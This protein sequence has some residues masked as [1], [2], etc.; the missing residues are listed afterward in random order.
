MVS[1]NTAD[2]VWQV[3]DGEAVVVELR[4][5]AYYSLNETGTYV[6]SRLVRG[7]NPDAIAATLAERLPVAPSAAAS[8]A[9]DF[10]RALLEAGLLVEG[11]SAG[12]SVFE[13]DLTIP[14]EYETPELTR[15]GKLEQLILSGE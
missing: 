2:A 1:L 5:S 6:L 4:T 10:V 14:A 9:S 7:E 15:H 11:S 8:A 3:L 12:P 13:H